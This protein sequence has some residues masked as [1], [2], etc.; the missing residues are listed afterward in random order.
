[1]SNRV[2]RELLLDVPAE[3]VWEAVT[4]DGWLADEVSFE[5]RPGGDAY[6]RSGEEVKNGWIEEVSNERSSAASR[7]SHWAPTCAI[8]ETASDSGAG[9]TR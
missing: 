8:H 5:L 4:G 9:V 6:F 2:E 7:S 1:M 3:E